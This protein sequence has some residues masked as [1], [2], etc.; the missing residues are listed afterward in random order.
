MLGDGPAH[1]RT[2]QVEALD[3]EL[4][5]QADGVHR[6]VAEPVGAPG[7]AARPRVTVVEQDDAVMTGE[8]GADEMPALMVATEPHQEEDRLARTRLLLEELEVANP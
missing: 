7:L 2:H 3:P 8:L 1:R 6:H 5:H 4:V